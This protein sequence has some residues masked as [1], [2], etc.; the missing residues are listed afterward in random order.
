M[1]DFKKRLTKGIIIFLKK[2]ETKSI[3]MVVSDIEIFQ[4]IKKRLEKKLFQNAK[5]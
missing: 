2:K 4:K 1:K 5:T 3:N